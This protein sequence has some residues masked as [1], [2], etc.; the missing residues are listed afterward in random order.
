MSILVTDEAESAEPS[1]TALIWLL[2][3]RSSVF[4]SNG[5]IIVP[6]PTWCSAAGRGAVSQTCRRED[7]EDQEGGS[8]TLHDPELQV[9]VLGLFW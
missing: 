9:L 8:F 6:D 2:W 1:P 4:G 3:K 7:P 5:G